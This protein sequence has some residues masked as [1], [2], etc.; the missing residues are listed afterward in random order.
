I[1]CRGA[2][3]GAVGTPWAAGNL[4]GGDSDD[5]RRGGRGGEGLPRGP[6]PGG[7]GAPARAGRAGLPGQMAEIVPPAAPP[8][9]AVVVCDDDAVRDWA[10]AAGARVVWCPGRGLNGAVAD[11]VA[12]LAADGVA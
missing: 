4:R 3:R 5:V 8:L 7:R 12:A 6:G 10:A 2:D 11:G 9:P 1:G